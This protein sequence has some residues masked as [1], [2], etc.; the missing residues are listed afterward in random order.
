[1]LAFYT[2]YDRPTDHPGEF[3][4]RKYLA[5]G[6]FCVACEIVARGENLAAV[7]KGLPDGLH[8]I[9]REVDDDP[10]IVEVWI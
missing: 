3:I 10:K 1:V 6:S 9:G 5:G 4:C 8:N 2:I 7:R